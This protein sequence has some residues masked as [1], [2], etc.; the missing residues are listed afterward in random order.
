M[1]LNKFL[2]G[3]TGM[4]RR[5]ADTAIQSGR[6]KINNQPAV[7]GVALQPGDVVE[8][9]GRIVTAGKTVTIMLN[10]PVGYVSSRAGQGS[11]TI[12]ELL[13]PE[14]HQLKPV[15]RLDKDSSGLMLLTNDGDLANRLTHP[16]Y[17][18]VKTYEVGLDKPLTEEHFKQITG[19]GVDIGDERPSRFKLE[20]DDAGPATAGTKWRAILSEGRNRQIRRTFLVLGYRVVILRRIKLG[21]L[22]L[23]DLAPGSYTVVNDAQML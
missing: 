16:R 3:A 2:A 18:K 10:K 5:A 11:K 15:G 6:V 9:D 20:P 1:R 7:M 22:T 8:L 4:S 14:L 12:Y 19:A 17:Q 23:N 13:P 21:A